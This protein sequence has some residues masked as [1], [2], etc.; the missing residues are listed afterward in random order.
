MTLPLE[1]RVTEADLIA[2]ARGGDTVAWETLTRQ[3]QE[4]VF[5]L[6]YLIL[7]DPADADDA[8][9]ETFIRAYHAL[10]R[11]DLTRAARPWLLSIAANTAR[12]RLR[13]VGR[14]LSALQRFLRADPAAFAPVTTSDP[15]E[16]QLLWQ[17]VHRLNAADQ[18]IIYLRYFS[19][20]SEAET[21]E[22]LG[23]A[24]GTV[25]SRTHRALERLRTVIDKDFPGLREG[26]VG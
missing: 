7:G 9:Q 22:A 21:A 8:A 25:K 26:V 4:A 10:D 20:M 16:S 13:S 2:R 17:A 24:P 14:H 1:G 3:H 19:E 15:S 12:N 23:I 11:F 18:E 6:A 5:R